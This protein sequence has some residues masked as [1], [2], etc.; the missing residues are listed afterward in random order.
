M[1]SVK[2]LAC[3]L[4][5]LAPIVFIACGADP[6]TPD[7]SD[8]IGLIPPDEKSEEPD[9][10][11][12]GEPRLSVD[13][14]YEG[15]RSETIKINNLRNHYFIFGGPELGRETYIQ[16]VSKVRL[17]GED[18]GEITLVGTPFWGGG[19]IWDEPIDLSEWTFLHVSFRSADRSFRTFEYTFLY[20]EGEMPQSVA[21]NVADYGY[22][23]DD[24]WHSLVIPLQ[25]AI[26]RGLDPSAVRSPFIIGA[27][28]GE[29]GHT[30]L[31]DNL[32]L[33]KF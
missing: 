29:S 12:I 6:D 18:A 2:R 31:I 11:Q 30:L 10:F 28:G 7:F 25:D 8:Q 27:G 13:L 26:A 22:T 17:E 16:G 1:R 21:L 32:Y 23:N 14:Y 5:A 24:E 33:T 4:V 19:I 15:G 9:P 20:G 3:A